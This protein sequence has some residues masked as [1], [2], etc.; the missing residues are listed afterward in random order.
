MLCDVDSLPPA[1]AVAIVAT[2]IGVGR[3]QAL[4]MPA[5]NSF[6]VISS[7]NG[8]KYSVSPN[9]GATTKHS[10][11]TTAIA[12]SCLGTD[13]SSASGNVS[14]VRKKVIDVEMDETMGVADNDTTSGETYAAPT[15]SSI[16]HS[17]HCSRSHATT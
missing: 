14:P 5:S 9:N 3:Q 15:L 4:K 13:L 17:S 1:A 12:D 7:A 11:R 10:N 6:C 8:R 16:S 2:N